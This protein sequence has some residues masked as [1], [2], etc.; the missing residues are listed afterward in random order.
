MVLYGLHFTVI[1]PV[2]V[3]FSLLLSETERY[4][5]NVHNNFSRKEVAHCGAIYTNPSVDGS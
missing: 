4:Y 2:E 3:P 1:G 5:I